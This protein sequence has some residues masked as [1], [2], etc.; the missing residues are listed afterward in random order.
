[1]SD[2]SISGRINAQLTAVA[3][4]TSPTRRIYSRRMGQ[5][6]ELIMLTGG[7]YTAHLDTEAG[8]QT[9]TARAGDIV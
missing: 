5:M 6:A 3:F 1:M 8:R 4:F 2:K 7:S 9:I